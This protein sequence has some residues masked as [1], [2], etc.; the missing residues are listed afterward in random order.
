MSKVIKLTK[1]AV[2]DLINE[3]CTKSKRHPKYNPEIGTL[4]ERL[5]ITQEACSKMFDASVEIRS[6]YRKKFGTAGAS[7]SKAD[8]VVFIDDDD[9]MPQV[10]PESEDQEEEYDEFEDEGEELVSDA[11]VEDDGLA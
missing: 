7:S 1:Q 5:N 10:T 6:A 3:G 8:E 2:V 9:T 11:V 4:L